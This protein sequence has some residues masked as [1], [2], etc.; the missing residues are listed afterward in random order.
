[1]KQIAISK[2][3]QVMKNN[4][5]SRMFIANTPSTKNTTKFQAPKRGNTSDHARDPQRY[6]INKITPNNLITQALPQNNG[7]IKTINRI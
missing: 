1:M 7:K 6:S 4:Y 3:Q 5:S 2:E